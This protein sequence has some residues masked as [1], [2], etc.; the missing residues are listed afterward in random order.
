MTLLQLW[1]ILLGIDPELEE[2]MRL[3]R[4]FTHMYE[5][6]TYDKAGKQLFNETY[7]EFRN[8]QINELKGFS[9]TLKEWRVLQEEHTTP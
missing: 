2:A 5:S 9:G 4:V 1:E 6:R 8:S 3:N 7:L